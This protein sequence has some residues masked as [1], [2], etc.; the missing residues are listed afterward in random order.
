[1]ADSV[2]LRADREHRTGR[3]A[4]GPQGPGDAAS[5]GDSPGP[6]RIR[7]P[8]LSGGDAYSS[9]VGILKYLLPAIAVGLVLLVIAWPRV[10][11]VKQSATV[12]ISDLQTEEPSNSTML[13]ARFDGIDDD[14]R[15]YRVT[16]DTATQR[17]DDERLVDL[18]NPSGDILTKDDTWIAV[19]SL[20][21]LYNKEEE[22]LD[23]EDGVTLFHDQG[24]EMRTE[25]AKIFMGEGRVVGRDPVDAQG[26][27]GN[28]VSEGIEIED[29]GA[30]VRFTGRAHM[31]IAAEALEQGG[32]GA[33]PILPGTGGAAGSGDA[34][35]GGTE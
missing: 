24:Y 31:E 15:P 11:P 22:V 10:N 26:P 19:T 1:M 5:G 4:P 27:S 12:G 18:E 6:G 7:P 30:V 29:N 35:S 20:S 33:A 23:L 32:G 28:I 34:G 2:T 14:G 13:N 9:V 3:G 21:G 8:R 16:A 17:P 25:T